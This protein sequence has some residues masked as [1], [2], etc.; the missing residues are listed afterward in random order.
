VVAD[1]PVQGLPRGERKRFA[2]G[3]ELVTEPS[4]I[5]LDEP[6]SGLDSR[7]AATV[8]RVIKKQAL[9]GRT[10]VAT[11]HVSVRCSS[12]IVVQVLAGTL[13]RVFTTSR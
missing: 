11:I 12:V 3:V 7:E 6:T 4:I 5:F 10:V 1:W 2:I 8:M 13:F 9:Q